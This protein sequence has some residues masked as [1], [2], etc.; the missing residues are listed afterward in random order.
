[1]TAWT[2]G[3][4]GRVRPRVGALVSVV[5]CFFANPVLLRKFL[6]IDK[7]ISRAFDRADDR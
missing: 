1:M 3:S 6:K 4:V 5:L 2:V 7:F